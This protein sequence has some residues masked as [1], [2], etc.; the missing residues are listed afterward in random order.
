M[1]FISRETF[2]CF[3]EIVF[4]SCK[5]FL[6]NY[7]VLLVSEICELYLHVYLHI[8]LASHNNMENLLKQTV[9]GEI[10]NFMESAC[11]SMESTCSSSSNIIDELPKAKKSLRKGRSIWE[12]S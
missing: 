10:R 1:L 12:G 9:Q 7:L 3:S 11:S 2:F 6:E 5:H 4:I 8:G